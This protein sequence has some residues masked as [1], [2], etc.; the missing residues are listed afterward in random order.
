MPPA[1]TTTSMPPSWP[2]TA[3]CARIEAFF[4]LPLDQLKHD[5]ARMKNE[6]DRIGALLP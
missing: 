1:P 6:L 3:S 5:R 2:P 4:S